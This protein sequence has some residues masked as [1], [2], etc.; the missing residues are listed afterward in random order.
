M[1]PPYYYVAAAVYEGAADRAV[2]QLVRGHRLPGQ[3]AIHA[4]DERPARLQAIISDVARSGLVRWWLY[5]APFP[6]NPARRAI[7][8]ALVADALKADARRLVIEHGD[9]GRNRL[10]RREIARALAAEQGELHYSHE[11]PWA[12]PGLELADVGAW[13]YRSGGE[14]RRR[15]TP[16]IDQVREVAH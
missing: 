10:D 3:R 15:V 9:D 5:V 16:L 14:W 12:H 1:R 6:T 7:L 2:R 4:R 13:A 11:M 8:A